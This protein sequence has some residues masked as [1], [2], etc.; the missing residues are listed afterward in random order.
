MP[1]VKHAFTNPKAD[2]ADTTITRP[3]DWNADHTGIQF[4]LLTADMGAKSDTALADVTSMSFTVAATTSYFFDFNVFWVAG[5]TTTGLSLSI[6]GPTIGAGVMRFAAIGPTTVTAFRMTAYGTA[7]EAL[8][9]IPDS[10][11]AGNMA[12]F[13]GFITTGATA[14]SVVLRY[15]PDA[16][17]T[18]TIQR[19]TFGK[20]YKAT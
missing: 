1:F 4:T 13:R 18:L 12:L 5:A 9:T 8:C 20:F 7:Y 15:A 6:N 10:I 17:A 16:A 11:I 2:G 3:S 14:G 19:G